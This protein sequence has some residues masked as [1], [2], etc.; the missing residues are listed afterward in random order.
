VFIFYYYYFFEDVSLVHIP[1]TRVRTSGEESNDGLEM[2][3]ARRFFDL[4]SFISLYSII[5]FISV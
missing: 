1:C 4:Q 3:Y 2:H 5:W